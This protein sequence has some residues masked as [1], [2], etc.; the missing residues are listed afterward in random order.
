MNTSALDG[1]A[2]LRVLLAPFGSEGDVAP[3]LWLADRL[4]ARGHR[5]RVAANP[6]FAD[7]V[8]R[9]G[10]D[11]YAAGSAE[12]LR[13][14]ME[15][16]RVWDG[17]KAPQ[18]L[19][20]S[21]VGSLAG[22]AEPF[23][24]AETGADL[25][26][27][28]SFA[29]GAFFAAESRGIPY[30][31]LHLQASALRS[32]G[33]LPVLGDRLGRTRRLPAP[34]IRGL[35]RLLDLGLDGKPLRQVN[36]FRAT[37]GLPPQRSFYRDV[38]NGGA[39]LGGLF[40]EWYAPVQPDW[41]TGIRLFG[42]PLEPAAPPAPLAEPVERFLA[43]GEK[44]VLWTHGSANYHTA[45]FVRAA[46]RTCA[47]LGV[48]GIVVAPRIGETAA[49][50]APGVLRLDYAPFDG[51]FPRCRALVHHGGIGTLAKALRAGLPQLVIPRAYDQFDNAARAER[52]GFGL[53][54][55]YRHLHRTAERLRA[56]LAEPRHAARAREL[57]RQVSVP[58]DIVAW[59]EGIA[60]GSRSK[61]PH[62]APAD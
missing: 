6:L 20:N 62:A 39:G 25:L 52:L 9:R 24:R 55:S 26:V 10:H 34:V 42:F 41:P 35:F 37:L 53:G 19:L 8:R 11:Y 5:V 29:L 45:D 4:V 13:V 43:G 49:P 23:L 15:D 30:V 31:R 46:E 58:A 36:R 14:T 60:I 28:S 1:F 2:P 61:S 56:L 7:L 22:C 51:L 47:Q 44:P 57:G 12:L 32:V 59:L 48:R 3:F 17:R 40:P 33:D 21:L 50:A 18:L 27:G 16:P 54:L 38:C